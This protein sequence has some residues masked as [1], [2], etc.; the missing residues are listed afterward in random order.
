MQSLLR[1]IGVGLD[2]VNDRDIPSFFGQRPRTLLGLGIAEQANER[3]L[4]FGADQF[5][6]DLD[7]PKLRLQPTPQV[8]LAKPPPC[9]FRKSAPFFWKLDGIS[10]QIR[11]K[12]DAI[13]R[14]LRV[15]ML[16][17]PTVPV[18]HHGRR[19]VH[20]RMA[21]FQHSEKHVEITTAIREGAYIQRRIKHADLAKHR[22]P[23]RHVCPRAELSGSRMQHRQ[24][25]ALGITWPIPLPHKTPAKTA[26][27]LEKHLRLSLEFVWH[28][29]PGHRH[30][31]FIARKHPHDGIGPTFIHHDIIVGVSD[32]VSLGRSNRT[33]ARPIKSRRRLKDVSDLRKRG[34]NQLAGR[35]GFRCVV[36]DQDLQGRARKFSKCIET[37]REMLRSIARA[38]GNRETRQRRQWRPLKLHHVLDIPCSF[39]NRISQG[40]MQEMMNETRGTL[41]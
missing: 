9:E 33:V 11:I 40:Q 13:V 4:Q 34:F 21:K 36:D 31:I 39:R 30:D 28:H 8:P 24:F 38:N 6:R 19:L 17:I 14:N 20:K 22:A 32:D 2:W 7:G 26:I 3:A 27:F 23:V 12:A 18:S 25:H 29:Q 41:I 35:L 16:E 1:S 5:V 15:K 37:N 10:N